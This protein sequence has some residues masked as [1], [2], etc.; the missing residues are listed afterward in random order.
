MSFKNI[1]CVIMIKLPE[2]QFKIIDPRGSSSCKGPEKGLDCVAK[3]VRELQRDM[4]TPGGLI[5]ASQLKT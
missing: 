4:G 3:M 1:Y 5:P 2:L